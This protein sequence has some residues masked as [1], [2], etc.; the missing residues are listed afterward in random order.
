MLS[1]SAGAGVLAGAV[2]LRR[3]RKGGE[4][5]TGRQKGRAAL[6][7]AAAIACTAAVFAL[8]TLLILKITP[9]FEAVKTRGSLAVSA[10]A[11]EEEPET[12]EPEKEESDTRQ[13]NI[14]TRDFSSLSNRE[15]IWENAIRYLL[16][17]P[18]VLIFG[19]S[20][21]DPMAGANETASFKAAHCHNV[22][23]EI[24]LESG[25]IGLL[26]A[27]AFAVYTAIHAFR[28]LNSRTLPLRTCIFPAAAASI[29]VG[30]LAESFTW[31]RSTQSLPLPVMF[32]TAGCICAFG[33][34]KGKTQKTFS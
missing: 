17:H 33:K 32:I 13:K 18:A 27:A 20:V 25:I 6:A 3:I 11:A 16:D 19:E 29:L 1:L 28:I 23:L 9:A 21:C 4:Q 22:I 8:S 26:I 12:E 2:L 15:V 14:T 24:L 30:D 34:R 31:F 5:E 10:A 7:W